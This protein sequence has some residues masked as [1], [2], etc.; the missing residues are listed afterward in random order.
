MVALREVRQNALQDCAE[1]AGGHNVFSPASCCCCVV[2]DDITH[3]CYASCRERATNTQLPRTCYKYTRACYILVKSL[4][5]MFML[6]LRAKQSKTTTSPPVL[7]SS[8]GY[9]AYVSTPLS[10]TLHSFRTRLSPALPAARR[11]PTQS[12]LTLAQQCPC[13]ICSDEFSVP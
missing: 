12:A 3:A 6:L 1:C 9:A 7:N 2:A 13:A 5:N 4:R 11:H 10:I 8:L